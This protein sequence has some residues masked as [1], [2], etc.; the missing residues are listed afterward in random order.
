MSLGIK[1]PIGKDRLVSFAIA[2]T[3]RLPSSPL[4]N[5]SA[6]NCK[7]C[8]RRVE[9]G[10]GREV[11]IVQIQHDKL[12]RYFLCGDCYAE[13]VDHIRRDGRFEVGEG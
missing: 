6:V 11:L 10:E 8:G 13:I 3:F 2:T 9:K 7:I 4:P 1:G 12:A 5:R